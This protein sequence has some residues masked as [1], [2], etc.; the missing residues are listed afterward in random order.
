MPPLAPSMSLPVATG[1]PAAL[2]TYWRR[3][4]WCE[5]ARCRSGSGRRRGR[6][7][8][9]PDV[10]GRAHDAV[11]A[12]RDRGAGQHHEVGVAAR[13]IERIVRL[14][15][16]EDRAAA[17]LVHE[18]EA[19]I[20]ELAEQR[21]PG[22]ER[23]E[24]PSSGAMLGRWTL[25]PCIAMPNGSSAASRTRAPPPDP[26]LYGVGSGRGV[27]CVNGRLFFGVGGVA[28]SPS[29][30]SSAAALAFCMTTRAWYS[31]SEAGLKV[32]DRRHAGKIEPSGSRNR[33]APAPSGSRPDY[34]ASGRQGDWKSC[35]GSGR[36]PASWDCSRDCS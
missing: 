18:V 30:S 10:V 34:P 3:N 22:V 14:Q 5:D 21:E 28:G 12:R 16:N 11:R 25:S 31:A 1:S 6:G 32:V 29:P 36:R 26:P 24:R 27:P 7:V 23:A 33:R 8:H 19:V 17:A 4:T 9:R 20:E 13:D 35:A 15:R 2:S